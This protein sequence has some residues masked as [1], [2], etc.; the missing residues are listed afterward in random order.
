M[1][2]QQLRY[3]I[4]VADCGSMNQAAAKLFVSQPSLSESIRELEREIGIRI[5]GR[6]NRGILVTP[7]GDEFLGYARQVV[8]QYRL[9]EERYVEKKKSRKKFSVSMQ[10]YSFAVKAFVEMVKQFGMEDYSFAVYETKTGNVIRDV[11][12]FVSEIGILYLSD[13]NRKVLEKI[14]LENELEFVPLFDCDTYIYV[15]KGNPLAQRDSVSMK[16]L[17][18]YP[19]LTFNQGSSNSFY[20][21]EEVHSTYEYKQ[22]VQ[23]SD[24]ASMLNLMVGLNGYTMCS[25][26]ICE[27]LNGGDYVAIP[28]DE[29]EVMTI[30]YIKRKNVMLSEMA[31]L[32]LRELMK[33]QELVLHNGQ[34]QK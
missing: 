14:F 31:S 19:C 10:H 15:W 25:G 7:E 27:E 2:I 13:F 23:V 5:F 29:T 17:E 28:L 1:T 8:E 11:H 22:T 16:D 4:T 34:V 18:P 30:G 20:F 26:F 24:R 32:Y 9:V 33:Y 21:A 12:D 3:I 6:T